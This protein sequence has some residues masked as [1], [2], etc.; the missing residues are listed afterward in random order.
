[1]GIRASN[2][3]DL[4]NR[5]DTEGPLRPL[6]PRHP[7]LHVRNGIVAP[8]DSFLRSLCFE[9]K[10]SERSRTLFALMLL[11]P[12]AI[13]HRNGDTDKNL[14]NI[15]SAL[16]GSTRETD[17]IGWYQ[18]HA[19]IGVIFTELGTSER[20]AIIEA[21]RAKVS[22]ALRARLTEQ[23]VKEIQLAFH[24]FP[25]DLDDQEPGNG[26]NSKLY[27]DLSRPENS[28]KLS[29][30][31]KRAMDI[32]GSAIALVILSPLFFLIAAIIKLT[33]KGPI[34]FRQARVGQFGV[35]FT[36]LKFRSMYVQNDP[37][38]HKEF[39]QQFIAGKNPAPSNGSQNA[40]YKITNDPRVT[41]FGRFL[42]RTSLDE[43]PQFLNVFKGEM[44]LV[45]PRPP[46]PYELESY[47]IWHR[48]RVLEAKPGITGLWQVNGRS[49]TRFDEM[50]RLDL[51]YARAWSLWL[52]IKILLRT[53]RAVFSG[54][55]AY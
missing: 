16:A 12:G 54:E 45:G 37:N 23:Q 9:R 52:D 19:V 25:E 1:M 3:S 17:I 43:L 41:P 26:V 30:N 20:D 4:K 39:V 7:S 28:R 5:V 2:I 10:R 50:V 47:D 55:G 14:R 46:I 24:I 31:L 40:V 18:H 49:K 53:P 34:L 35:H 21:I 36:F 38:L 29:R 27:P 15:V 33:S 22:T 42:R 32:L 48:R 44:S 6:T 13:S 11:D 8:E 51:Q